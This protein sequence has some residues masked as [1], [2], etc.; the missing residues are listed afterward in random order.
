MAEEGAQ[1][2][3]LHSGRCLCGNCV[4]REGVVEQLIFLGEEEERFPVI[5][6]DEFEVIDQNG[7]VYEVRFTG[8]V[9]QVVEPSLVR[10]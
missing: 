8:E 7:Y 6:G 2:I 10:T 1:R 5:W 9:R 3:W 4:T